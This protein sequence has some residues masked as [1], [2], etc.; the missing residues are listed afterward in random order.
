MGWIR[1]NRRDERVVPRRWRGVRL[2]KLL[3]GA[4]LAIHVVVA[5]LLVGPNPALFHVA[6][7]AWSRAPAA[8]QGMRVAV[9]RYDEPS[10]KGWRHTV[11]GAFAQTGHSEHLARGVCGLECSEGRDLHPRLSV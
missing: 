9:Y 11:P 10:G 8:E 2:L 7:M 4:G 3:V 1:T 6:A 5:L